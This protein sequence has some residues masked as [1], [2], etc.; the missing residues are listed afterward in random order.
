VA[1]KKHVAAGGDC[2]MIITRIK[3]SRTLSILIAFTISLI[4]SSTGSGE[5]FEY[6]EIKNETLAQELKD[7]EEISKLSYKITLIRR[8]I[9]QSLAN[10]I[11]ESIYEH[12]KDKMDPDLILAIMSVESWFRPKAT[13]PTGAKGLMQIM[14]LWEDECGT[15]LYNIDVNIQCG[16]LVYRKYEAIFKRVDMTLTAYNRGPKAVKIDMRNGI[17]PRT[18]YAW[19]IIKRYKQLK[20]AGFDTKSIYIAS[21]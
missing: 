14:P 18:N 5:E 16:I 3:S 9:D 21:L 12:S 8:G 2:P 1:K 6:T 10:K 20:R 17:D 15:D 19:L 13:S 7:I 4:T 11:A